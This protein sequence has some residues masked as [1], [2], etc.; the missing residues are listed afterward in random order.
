VSALILAISPEVFLL[1][2]SLARQFLGHLEIDHDR[3]LYHLNIVVLLGKGKVRM[4]LVSGSP[5][6]RPTKPEQQNGF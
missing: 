3:F 5:F 2:L 6:T 1:F 4:K